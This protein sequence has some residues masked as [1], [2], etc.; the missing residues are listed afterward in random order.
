MLFALKASMNVIFFVMKKLPC[1]HPRVGFCDIENRQWSWIYAVSENYLRG[2]TENS[3]A[4]FKG[5]GLR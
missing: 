4:G 3:I 5:H 1:K 2:Q